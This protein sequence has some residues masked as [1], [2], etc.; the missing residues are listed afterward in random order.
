MPSK[1]F[2]HAHTLNV[3]GVEAVRFEQWPGAEIFAVRHT[4]PPSRTQGSHEAPPF[5]ES[6]RSY[7]TVR[8]IHMSEEMACRG[9][10]PG[11]QW[12]MFCLSILR[13]RSLVQPPWTM[14]LVQM[15]KRDLILVL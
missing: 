8:I 6:K 4:V 5:F 10:P 1:L 14:Q 7:D 2:T 9:V 15:S 11:P 12:C 13:E 3:L